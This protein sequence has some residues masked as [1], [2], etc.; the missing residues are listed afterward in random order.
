MRQSTSGNQRT[1]SI[2][3]IIS[4]TDVDSATKYDQLEAK[5]MGMTRKLISMDSVIIKT[6]SLGQVEY[7]P[8]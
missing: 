3:H 8:F 1:S 4:D 5:A 6:I 7:S 2:H